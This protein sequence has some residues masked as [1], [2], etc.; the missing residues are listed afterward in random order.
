[1]NKVVNINSRHGKTDEENMSPSFGKK[2]V[3]KK[4]KKEAEKPK[5]EEAVEKPKEEE[6]EEKPSAD[7]E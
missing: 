5:E 7:E 1:M 6:P 3:D 2:K 4:P